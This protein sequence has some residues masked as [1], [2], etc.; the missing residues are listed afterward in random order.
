[1]SPVK[2]PT[3]EVEGKVEEPVEAGKEQQNASVPNAEKKNLTKEAPLAQKKLV[4]T[5]EPE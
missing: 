3:E 4:Q 5:A 1:M 2:V